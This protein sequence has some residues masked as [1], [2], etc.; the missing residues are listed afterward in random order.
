MAQLYRKA[1]LDKLS[2]PEQ[3]DKMIVITSP[4]LWI[5]MVGAV[6]IVT[7]ALVWSVFGELPVKQEAS[8]ILV[9]DQGAYTLAAD[10]GG[11]VSTVEVKIGDHVKEGDVMVVLADADVKTELD[12]LKERYEK[13]EAVT[14]DSVGDIVTQDNRELINMKTQI[15]T[16]GVESEQQSA[17][18]A[19]YQADLAEI[20]PKVAEAEAAK[21]KAKG[22]YYHMLGAAPDNS[23]EL[24]FSEAQSAYNQSLSVYTS[25]SGNAD[26]AKASYKNTLQSVLNSLKNTVKS[27]IAQLESMENSQTPGEGQ[28][29]TD[30]PSD[31]NQ[32]SDTDASEGG[33]QVLLITIGTSQYTKEEL[34]VILTDLNNTGK[35]TAPFDFKGTVVSIMNAADG[36]GST[37]SQLQQLWIQYETAAEVSAEAKEEYENAG[38]YYE[39][40]KQNYEDY[41][42]ASTSINIQKEKLGNVY[43]E[44]NNEYNSLYSQEQQIKSQ[45]ASLEGQ[46][47]AAQISAGIQTKSYKQQ[48]E[49]TKSA[50]L[51]NLQTEIDKYEYNL[52]KTR[53]KSSVSGVVSDIKVNE[54]A[55]LGQGNDVVTIRQLSEE[56]L[57]VCYIPL[58]SGKKVKPGMPV[59]IKPTTINEQEYGHMEA[60]VVKID[61]YVATAASMRGILGDDTLV[62]AFTQNGPVVGVTCRLRTDESTASGYWWSNKK[63]AD[64]MITE[65]TL[66][67]AD[68]VIE[69]KKPISMI[70]P[71][72]KEKLTMAVEPE[73][74]QGGNN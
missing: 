55:A 19:M 69:K 58:N 3:L 67:S 59:I 56:N 26:T 10:T 28:E 17:M 14:L 41:A 40:A 7:V 5:A 68:I 49:A 64:I 53:I 52:E 36:N 33:Q 30:M 6:L 29:G 45:I 42:E 62:Q 65:G 43:N 73:Q 38:S 13:V 46:L 57:I 63:G 71:L 2:S 27:A 1:L 66:I 20:S 44:L 72:L 31:E 54:G 9:P 70:I 35:S 11:I 25:Y 50:V 8:G 23:A 4:S 47:R 37:Y 32:A 74:N 48:F 15:A 24:E 12:A 16:A 21:E 18:L 61:E 34:K 22:D 60:E 39:S 51:D